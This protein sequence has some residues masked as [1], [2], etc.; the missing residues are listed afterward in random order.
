[1]DLGG[2]QLGD[3]VEQQILH[4]GEELM[5]G[6]VALVVVAAQGEEVA[7]L[8][9]EALLRGADVADALQ[10]LVEVVRAAIGVLE[11]LVVHDEALAQVFAEHG[12]GPAT[13]LH[14]TR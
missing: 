8:L 5:G 10:H 9:V 13:E 3:G 2:G 11:P 7:N 12:G 1:M 6:A 4:G 14:P